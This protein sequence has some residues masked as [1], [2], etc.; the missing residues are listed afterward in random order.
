M[1]TR[2]RPVL[3]AISGFLLGA[4]VALDLMMFK[5]RPLD[6]VS[7]IGLPVIGLVLGIA[8]AMVAPFGR[9]RGTKSEPA[10]ATS[11]AAPPPASPEG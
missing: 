10:V 3:G 11:T 5:V 4:F 1:K 8:L 6:T 2:G 9:G 7:V